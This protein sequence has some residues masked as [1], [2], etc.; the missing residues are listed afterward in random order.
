VYSFVKLHKSN[1]VEEDADDGGGWRRMEEL[2]P[3]K[4]SGG[5][6]GFKNLTSTYKDIVE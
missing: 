3:S 4:I 5:F 6:H 2:G 1:S